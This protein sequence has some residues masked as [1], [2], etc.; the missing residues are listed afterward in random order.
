[1][2][3]TSRSASLAILSLI[4]LL[5]ATT[6]FQPTPTQ[7]S[8]V[9]SVVTDPK[10]RKLVFGGCESDPYEAL[11][12]FVAGGAKVIPT[13]DGNTLKDG[14]DPAFACR[15][16]KLFQAMRHCNP[17]ITSGYRGIEDQRR[18]CIR[19]CGNP[20]GCQ[21]NQGYNGGCAKPGGSCHQY[22]LAVDTS[23]SCAAQMSAKAR[24]FGLISNIPGYPNPN[25]YQCLEHGASAGRGSCTGPCNGGLPITGTG[26]D[27]TG[28]PSAGF[29]NNLR[30]MF[31]PPPAPIQQQPTTPAPPIGTQNSTPYAPGTCSPQFY[32]QNNNLYYRTSSC[33]DQVSQV[34]PDGCEA[35][36]CK[37]ARQGVSDLL[38][39]TLSDMEKKDATTTDKKSTSTLSAFD[40]I[41]LIADPDAGKSATTTDPFELT[42]DQN[43][44]TRLVVP[45]PPGSLPQQPVPGYALTPSGQ[46][47]FVSGDLMESPYVNPQ[48]L[49]GFQSALSSM[50]AQL[51]RVVAYLRPFGRPIPE[52]EHDHFE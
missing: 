39:S 19:V 1:M 32:C 38:G 11:R 20:G 5:L 43:S 45:P 21:K 28:P 8:T 31:S 9:G 47:T 33:V 22:G 16:S 36:S 6:F 25:H 46:Q 34:C 4:V 27:Q 37:G 24:E 51:E 44:A 49:T 2:F 15:L 50:R 17:K 18:A 3:S 29:T 13:K 10:D 41:N 12:P 48:Q 42:I 30:N 35:G 52:D 14:I 7:G 26:G 40:Q 23:S